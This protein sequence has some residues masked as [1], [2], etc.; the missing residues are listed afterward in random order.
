VTGPDRWNAG[1]RRQV[2]TG[3]LILL[4]TAFLAVCTT[5]SLEEGLF[6]RPPDADAGGV[7]GRNLVAVRCLR[8]GRLEVQGRPAALDMVRPAVERA[9]AA[10]NRTIVVVG[11]DQ[12]CY[13]LVTDVLD[14][15]RLAEAP[16]VVL[17]E[18]GN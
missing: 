15:V 4:V 7:G 8:D 10:D 16:R 18:R 1:E 2:S 3:D 14:Q 11:A 9:L 6:L 17:R 12:G 13:Q 5:F